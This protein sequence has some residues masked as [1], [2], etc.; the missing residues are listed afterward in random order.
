ML[1]HYIFIY[2]FIYLFIIPMS[3]RV[4]FFNKNLDPIENGYQESLSNRQIHLRN[5]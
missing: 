4:P 5:K 1:D 3:K 2:L